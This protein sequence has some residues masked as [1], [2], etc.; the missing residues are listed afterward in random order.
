MRAADIGEAK[1]LMDERYTTELLFNQIKTEPLDLRV[2][3]IGVELTSSFKEKM[4]ELLNSYCAAR[5]R[6]IDT[7][8]GELGV[9]L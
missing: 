1:K 3:S 8:L 5:I 7:R 6:A 4:I 9:D 2:G